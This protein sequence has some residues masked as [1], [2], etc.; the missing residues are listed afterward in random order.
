MRVFLFVFSIIIIGAGIY[1]YNLYTDVA[2]AVDNM[3]SP[4]SRKTSEKREVQVQFKNQDP[5]SFL[6][7][8]VDERDGDAGRTDSMLVMTVN[9]KKKSTEIVSI[10]RDTRTKI[11][12]KEEP[13]ESF[14]SKINHAYAYGGIEMSINTVENFLNIPI[15]YYVEINMQGFKDIVDSVGGIDVNNKIAFELDGITLAEG[16][17]T[18]N[19][20]QALQYARMRKQDPKGDFGRQER[21]REVISKVIDKGVSLSSLANHN[22]ILNALQNNIKTNL[23]FNDMLD[24]QSEY[25]PATETIEKVEIQGENKRTDAWYFLV[26]DEE[27]QALS[28]KLREHLD[29]QSE[30]IKESN[31]N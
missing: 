5:L 17:Q 4:I 26:D 10:P 9:P 30:P 1:A 8:G 25:K 16:E 28:D 21:Q 31:N 6:L 29:L 11:I 7:V 19:G 12:N 20:E 13:S 23:T 27:R 15:D 18:L 14:T 24:I 3:H 2:S 22:K